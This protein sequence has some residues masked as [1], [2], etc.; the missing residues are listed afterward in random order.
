M[1][2]SRPGLGAGSLETPGDGAMRDGGAMKRRCM[3]L[4]VALGAAVLLLLPA[5]AL[6]ADPS[7]TL[8]AAA[9]SV[10]AGKTLRFS[11]AVRHPGADADKVV[12]FRRAG[13]AWQRVATV[14]LS[15]GHRFSF[16]LRFATVGVRGVQVRY[17]AGGAVAR[18]EDV[19]VSVVPADDLLGDENS[20]FGSLLGK[21]VSGLVSGAASNVGN[22]A[23]GEILSLLGW[24]SNSSGNAAALQAMDAKLDQIEADLAQILVDL[25][26]LMGELKITEEQILENTNDPTA[27]ITE[28]GTY[29]DELQGMADGVSPGGGNQ[30]Q[31]L[32]YATQVEDDFR[33]E[34]DVNTIHDA[35][36][37]PD[38]AKAPV[39]ANFTDLSINQMAQPNP[40][41]LQTAYLGLEQ[42]FTQLIYNQLRGVDLVVEAKQAEAAAGQPV[43]TSASVYLADF[44]T[45][46]LAP[47]V[48]DFLDNVWRLILSQSELDHT[49][50]FLPSEAGSIV[51]RAEFLRTQILDMDHFGLR[52]HVVVT[53]D[54]SGK[55]DP[56]MAHGNGRDWTPVTESVSAVQGSTYD[57]WSGRTVKPS[58]NYAILTCDFGP[59]TAGTYTITGPN[60]NGLALG[61]A[62]V[63]RYDD[64]YT[65][66]AAGTDV[67]GSSVGS[68]RTGGV[69]GFAKNVV[70]SSWV[71][72][73]AWNV[74]ATGTPAQSFIGI[75]GSNSNNGFGGE[76]EADYGFVYGGSRPARMS[77]PVSGNPNGSASVNCNADAGGSAQASMGWGLGVYDQTAGGF[78]TTPVSGSQTVNTN[79][80][81]NMNRT[82]TQTFSFTA[83]PGHAYYVFFNAAVS[84]SSQY[85]S[86]SAKMQVGC[87]GGLEV[88]FPGD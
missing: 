45:N 13:T 75:Q 56:V 83:Q 50:G 82:I 9:G 28:I 46:K 35:I 79:Q 32:A 16:K 17:R 81:A 63:Q 20:F 59:A 84:G 22:D 87:G 24:G 38:S 8:T 70:A 30:T 53:D 23:M 72:P 55:L 6:A 2:R 31:I 48:Q 18:S 34:N 52:A 66:D 77:V 11:G 88:Q 5:G 1:L 49:Q 85:G 39:L 64:D 57:S 12:V 62:V 10:T 27:A 78:A 15:P 44:R 74:T 69:E 73:G 54:W 42:Y 4:A 76:N 26:N 29:M 19:W 60:Y 25:G 86:A 7:V 58:T 41:D 43:G 65:L 14:R 67:Y 61:T 21:V 47:E 36:L 80:S 51:S 68:T 37:P 3:G 33:I 71:H 40:P